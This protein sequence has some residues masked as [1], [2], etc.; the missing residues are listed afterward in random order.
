MAT[1]SG[2][3]N[4]HKIPELRR[5]ILFTL[6]MLA[7]YR[8]GVFVTA[9]GVDRNA[10]RQFVQSQS[11]NLLG[12]FNLFSGGALE[13]LSIFALGIMPYI[14]ASIIMQLMGMVYKPIDELKKEGEAGRRKLD[15]YTRYGTVALSAFQAFGISKFIEGLSG[16]PTG[17]GI[18]NNPGPG[19]ELM[20]VL[21][22]TTGTAFLMW[23]GEQ[24]TERGIGNGI[25]LII[26]ASIITGVPGYVWN[27][28]AQ[29]EGDVRPLT[30]AAV[31]AILIACIAI[32]A[33]FENGRRLIPIVY[34]RRQVGRRVY[35]GQ[36][37][38]L[39]LKVNTAGVIPPIFASSLLMFPATLASMNVPGMNELTDIVN[40]GDWVFN[41]GFGLL[42][43]FFCFFYT[44]VVFNP[45]DVAENLKKQQA[46]IPGIRP[47]KQTAEFIDHVMQR[48]TFAGAMYVAFIC[49]TPGILG[50]AIRVPITFGGTS[51]MIVVGV[52]L[53]TINQIE[54]HLLKRSYEGLTGPGGGRVRGRR[55]PAAG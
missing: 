16:G 31:V 30:A 41:T 32:V 52:A 29:N 4:W 45:V 49:V 46:N 28:F 20:T 27:Y 23:L 51:I 9:P 54:G 40:R 22:L 47:G 14:S 1:L 12:F 42:I 53:D 39:P 44:N 5:R 8:V 34:S 17:A 6:G 55:V 43:I 2:I 25:S 38:H 24:I 13:N 11:G 21:T 18:V 15:Q 37:A 33:F 7:V 50:N 26:M 36:T 35:G 3:Q 10:M 19:F 48:I